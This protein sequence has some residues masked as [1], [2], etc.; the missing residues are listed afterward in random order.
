[1]NTLKT[2]IATTIIVITTGCTPQ[3]KLYPP[4]QSGFSNGAVLAAGA[5]GGA[6]IGNSINKD[7]G[8]PVGAVVGLGAG[9]LTNSYLSGKEREAY[10]A[11]LAE[12]ARQERS[13][14]M[15]EYWKERTL[16]LNQ[17]GQTGGGIPNPRGTDSIYYPAGV[18]DGVRYG[19]RN[20]TTETAESPLNR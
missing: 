1:M 10:F 12:G 6:Y 15:R 5:G 11:G 14:L 2:G 17:N 16:S 13:K 20:S 8:A 7:Y 19:P 3:P 4:E 18:V 9:M